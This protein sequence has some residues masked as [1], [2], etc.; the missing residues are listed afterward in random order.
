[1]P[2]H[3][4]LVQNAS[5]AGMR[6]RFP[7]SQPLLIRFMLCLRD[8]NCSW[9]KVLIHSPLTFQL[10]TE[11]APIEAARQS[12]IRSCWFGVNQG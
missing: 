9:S 5:T 2:C 3:L 4:L 1:M 12:R 6:T 8:S 7:Y 10:Q 11:A